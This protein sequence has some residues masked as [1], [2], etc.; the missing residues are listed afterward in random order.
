[1]TENELQYMAGFFDAEG[2]VSMSIT[3]GRHQM[4]IIVG[5]SSPEV[6]YNFQA[7]F[8]GAV[9]R[10]KGATEKHREQWQWNRSIKRND[11]FIEAMQG[12]V[13][14]KAI[15]IE[16]ASRFTLTLKKTGGRNKI[17]KSPE[18]IARC[19]MTEEDRKT[20]EAI[21][22]MMRRANRGEFD[23]EDVVIPERPAAYWAGLFDG[24]GN[25]HAAKDS[26]SRAYR[27]TVWIFSAYKPILDAAQ[28]Q[29]GG[30]VFPNYRGGRAKSWS[31]SYTA[32]DRF[33]EFVRPHLVMKRDVVRK[34][35]ELRDLV[36]NGEKVSVR[37]EK[38][39]VR[40][41]TDP[42]IAQM[43][44]IVGEMRD[45]NRLGPTRIGV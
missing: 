39:A 3:N 18:D 15:P 35:L 19:M 28:R 1:M 45:M 26:R 24:D 32:R 14:I 8:G 27:P 9:F 37:L 40:M 44:A 7:S 16:L 23:N 36:N 6:L 11:E 31:A 21:T 20:R 42:V 2:H 29:F 22:I 43:N 30:A 38:S 12:R 10:T 4:A 13:T 33:L 41:F 5:Q 25:I 17:N 34:A